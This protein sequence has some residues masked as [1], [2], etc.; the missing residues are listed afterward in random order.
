MPAA[1]EMAKNMASKTKMGLRL[2]KDALNAG[3]NLSSLED[4]VK[5]EDRNQAFL[6]MSGLYKDQK[7]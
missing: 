4:T 7:R 1:L 2:T 5:I 6:F 3:I